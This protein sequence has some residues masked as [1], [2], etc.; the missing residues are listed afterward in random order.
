[1][2]IGATA[3]EGTDDVLENISPFVYQPTETMNPSFFRN[4]M[5]VGGIGR[6][7]VQPAEFIIPSKDGTLS[8][9]LVR[10]R[11]WSQNRER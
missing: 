4:L 8:S 6:I 11:D 1:V 10:P 5:L 2:N 9:Q 7:L 3:L